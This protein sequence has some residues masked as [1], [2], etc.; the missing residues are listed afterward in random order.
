MWLNAQ[1]LTKLTP[2]AREAPE[3]PDTNTAVARPADTNASK[4]FT[5]DYLLRDDEDRPNL[6]PACSGDA[7]SS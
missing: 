2:C 7:K 4:P 1:E 5:T 3:P 6:E